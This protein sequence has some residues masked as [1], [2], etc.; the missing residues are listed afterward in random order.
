VAAQEVH[1]SALELVKRVGLSEREQPQ[2]RVEGAGLKARLGRG[3][4]AFLAPR[5]FLG[6][7]DGALEECRRRR[8]TATSLRPSSRTLE[9]ERNL[10]IRTGG[11]RREMPRSAIWINLGIR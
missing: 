4:G 9:L 7:D 5:G 8:E 3:Q 1:E 10:L 2:H 11:G 6:Q